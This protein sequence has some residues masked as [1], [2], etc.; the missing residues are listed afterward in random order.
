MSSVQS[1]RISSDPAK[2]AGAG[3]TIHVRLNGTGDG[4]SATKPL[5]SIQRALDLAGPGDMVLIAPGVYREA[6]TV[7]KSGTPKAYLTIKGIPGDVAWYAYACSQ[8]GYCVD[9]CDQFYG[10][11]WESQSPRGKFYWLRE[12][13]EGRVEWDVSGTGLAK[14]VDPYLQ[15]TYFPDITDPVI[16]EVRR[17]RG[18]ELCLEGFRFAGGRF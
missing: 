12:Y 8:C 16:L 1:I 7:T 5:G 17:E 14:V 15:T 2:P 6:V 11:G 4:S 9:E 18:I 13:M 10:R 3:R